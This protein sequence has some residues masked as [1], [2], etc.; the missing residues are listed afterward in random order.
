MPRRIH[1]FHSSPCL[2]KS[3]G[4][5]DTSNFSLLLET[6]CIM[7]VGWQTHFSSAWS[8]HVTALMTL[9]ALMLMLVSINKRQT[10]KI[11]VG[12][13]SSFWKPSLFWNSFLGGGR[14]GMTTSV[15]SMNFKVLGS[16]QKIYH[17]SSSCHCQIH[18][19][20]HDYRSRGF[21]QFLL[22]FTE[23]FNIFMI[24]FGLF[25]IRSTQSI[26]L[27]AH[28]DEVYRGWV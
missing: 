18:P 14:R 12:L 15:S 17:E 1:K 6:A 21:L 4:L 19:T 23:K 26:T 10:R 25:A 2:M 5:N 13:K 20:C 16:V 22:M 24:F 3:V 9:D 11:V 7:K 8:S 28:I 27:N